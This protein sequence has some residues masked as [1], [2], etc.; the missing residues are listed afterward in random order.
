MRC[1]AINEDGTNSYD[2]GDKSDKSNG[3]NFGNYVSFTIWDTK[4][5]FNSWRKGLHE[6]HD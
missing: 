2:E 1:V 5:D 3:S 4:S 6:D